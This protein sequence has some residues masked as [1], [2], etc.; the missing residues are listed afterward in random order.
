MARIAQ[1]PPKLTPDV[2]RKIRD[3]VADIKS[4]GKSVA[5]AAPVDWV[6][7]QAGVRKDTV[8]RW[9]KRASKVRRLGVEGSIAKKWLAFIDAFDALIVACS[10]GVCESIG[11]IAQDTESKKR[12]DA[13]HILLKRQDR[14]ADVI[15]AMDGEEEIDDSIAHIPQDILDRLTDED[16]DRLEKAQA[17]LAAQAKIVEDIVTSAAEAGSD[18]D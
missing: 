7:A 12:L 11:E 2:T 15:A 10:S 14:E 1:P 5:P 3:K 13:L 6:G 4:L 8:R 17:V 9:A 16:M 18:D